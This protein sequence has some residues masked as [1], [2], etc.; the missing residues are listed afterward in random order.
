MF[1]TFAAALSPIVALAAN[2]GNGS[3]LDRD[4][5]AEIVL[6]PGTLSLFTYNLW[7][8]T[9][10]EFHGDLSWTVAKPVS[11][12]TIPAANSTYNQWVEY[13]FCFR[14]A[15]PNNAA[16]TASTV[17]DCLNSR[18]DVL[19]ATP[20]DTAK[21]ATWSSTFLVTDKSFTGISPPA[22]T[23]YVTSLLNDADSVTTT[24]SE[25]GWVT[26]AA[27]NSKTGCAEAVAAADTTP[28]TYWCEN[29]NTHYFRNFTTKNTGE[30]A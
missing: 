23:D 15:G 12:E 17:W 4:N 16:A 24:K 27:N 3:G 28:A 6:I 30:D 21:T 1:K 19:N 13:G 7:N 25:V 20:S 29:L 8:G 14:N 5:A 10:D 18:A 2:K 9:T 22:A 26:I 11:P